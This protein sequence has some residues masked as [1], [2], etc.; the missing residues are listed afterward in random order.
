MNTVEW[1]L[2]AAGFLDALV[3]DMVAVTNKDAR[4]LMERDGSFIGRLQRACFDSLAWVP[5][6]TDV[7]ALARHVGEPHTDPHI[8]TAIPMV[9][10]AA[11]SGDMLICDA[12]PEEYEVDA[13]GWDFVRFTLVG[14]LDDQ[15]SFPIG[16]YVLAMRRVSDG[17]A[18]LPSLF[19]TIS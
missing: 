6:L 18:G 4:L 16:S 2:V 9:E 17:D 11:V 8:E 5:A 1:Q 7:Q 19:L 3:A 14:P 10:N 12:P 13:Y 15:T